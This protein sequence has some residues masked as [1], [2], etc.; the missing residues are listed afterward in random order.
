MLANPIYIKMI[1]K[2]K[3]HTFYIQYINASQFNIHQNDKEKKET[4]FTYNTL[5]LANSIYIKTIKEKKK[6]N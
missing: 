2:K 6:K 4:L 3:K 5:T 1:K